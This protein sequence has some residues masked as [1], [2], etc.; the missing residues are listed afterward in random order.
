MEAG[1]EHLVF[2]GTNYVKPEQGRVCAFLLS[3]LEIEEIIKKSG[4]SQV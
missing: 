3:K 1:V 2:D 4:L